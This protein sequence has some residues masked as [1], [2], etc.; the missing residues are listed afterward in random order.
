MRFKYLV[1]KSCTYN[2]YCFRVNTTRQ[3]INITLEWIKKTNNRKV[4]IKCLQR[5][6]I[7]IVQRW[8]WEVWSCTLAYKMEMT[9]C[10]I[11]TV[12]RSLGGWCVCLLVSAVLLVVLLT[13]SWRSSSPVGIIAEQKLIEQQLRHENVTVRQ[14]RCGLRHK[15]RLRERLLA[16]YQP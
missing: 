6:H 4:K 9:F 3:D 7:Q 13:V 10:I 2:N 15:Q 12:V 14:K 1:F 8:L 11:F 5:W 16:E